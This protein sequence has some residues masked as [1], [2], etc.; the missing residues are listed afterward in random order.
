MDQNIIKIAA[1]GISYKT[2]EVEIREQAALSASEQLRVME[3]LKNFFGIRGVMTLS[4]CNRTEIYISD[5][6]PEDR[7][8][9]VRSWLDS[10]KQIK[11]I[12]T[13]DQYTYVY[14]HEE[15]AAHLF[16]VMSGMDSQILGEP[17]ITG[18][19]KDSYHTALEQK[20]TDTY[21]NKLFNFGMQAQKKVR[22]DTFL[23]DGAISVSFAGVELAK[24][25]FRD[26][27][28]KEILLV[29]AGDTAE[30][31]AKHFL[32][33]GVTAIHIANRTLAKAEL[34]TGE[35]GGKAYSLEQLPAV[36]QKAD[37]VISATS[38]REYVITADM[39]REVFRNRKDKLI[40]L[41]DLAIPRDIDPAVE[42]IDGVFS[43]NLD[44]LN[45]VVRLN[46]EK[47]ESEIPKAEKIISKYIDDYK[48]WL[49]HHSLG[50]TIAKMKNRFEEIRDNEM[51]YVRGK[52]K[53]NGLEE[54]ELLTKSMMNKIMKYHIQSLKKSVSDPEKYRIHKELLHSTFNLDSDKAKE[55]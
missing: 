53:N 49:L 26:L 17:Q 42:E 4:T 34:L 5:E 28:G 45:Q 14:Y 9:E 38:S 43:Y 20:H 51:N 7:V 1:I 12:Y 40:F 24:K 6:A 32:D 19:V 55:E 47:R 10:F 8:E 52:L 16:R 21:L 29:G 25:L 22:T 30:L 50:S 3:E 54:I 36:L 37:I 39:M 13:N 35:I 31:A 41:I 23:T 46:L 48:E 18:Q 2:A 44:D 27:G 11:G 33:K 15:A